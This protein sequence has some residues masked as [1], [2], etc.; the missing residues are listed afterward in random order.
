MSGK[1]IE[2]KKKG[3]ILELKYESEYIDISE[4]EQLY[5]ALK[6]EAIEQNEAED[7]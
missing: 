1:Y 4:L 6:Q 7:F 5:N 3:I 2:A